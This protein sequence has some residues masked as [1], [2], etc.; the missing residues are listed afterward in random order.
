MKVKLDLEILERNRIIMG[1]QY[2][3]RS[4]IFRMLRTKVLSAMNEGGYS[5]IAI[6]SP[7][8]GAGKTMISINLAI[9]MAKVSKTSVILIDLDLRRPSVHQVL[10]L[11]PQYGLLDY[12][13]SE[14][15]FN[16]VLLKPDIDNLY[17]VPARGFAVEGRG[18]A[19]NSSDLISSQKMKDTIKH[20]TK[21]GKNRLIIFDT[22][23]LLL[24]D[25]VLSALP[26]VDSTLLVAEDGGNTEKELRLAQSLLSHTR[27]IGC[28]LNKC[29]NVPQYQY[30]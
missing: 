20:I 13:T 4:D 21:N 29:D 27:L 22:P 9:A 17:I 7:L 14:A 10:G 2:D 5:S 6:C 3:P 19:R 16:D 12:L 1:L 8:A 11:K 15:E 18:A 23:P 25:D 28:V 26:Y 30:Y 24:T